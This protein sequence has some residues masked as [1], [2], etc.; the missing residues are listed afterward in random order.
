MRDILTSDEVELILCY[1]DMDMKAMPTA[2]AM[3]INRTTMWRKFDRIFSQTGFNPREFWDLY[4]IIRELEKEDA[5]AR[6]IEVR[7]EQD[8]S[9]NGRTQGKLERSAERS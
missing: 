5:D 3:H 6:E 8:H 4:M 1:A 7:T 2:N 9:N